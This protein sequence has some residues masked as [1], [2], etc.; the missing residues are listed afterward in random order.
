MNDD[1]NVDAKENVSPR[2]ENPFELPMG[3]P[4]KLI[5]VK[6][7]G[8]PSVSVQ[9]AESSKKRKREHDSESPENSIQRSQVNEQTQTESKRLRLDGDLNRNKYYDRNQTW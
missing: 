3:S 6:N 4:T 9:F 7:I 2:N 5:K 8:I 1:I